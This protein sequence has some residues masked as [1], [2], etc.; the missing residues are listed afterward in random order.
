MNSELSLHY[1]RHIPSWQSGAVDGFLRRP[2]GGVQPTDD[3]PVPGRRLRIVEISIKVVR[4]V[5]LC[6]AATV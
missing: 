6:Y 2:V 4:G 1:T 5:T 3:V